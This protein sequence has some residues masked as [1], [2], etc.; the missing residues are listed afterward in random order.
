MYMKNIIKKFITITYLFFV[1]LGVANT[2]NAIGLSPV[3]IDV[4]NSPSSIPEDLRSSNKIDGKAL[5][6]QKITSITSVI[7][8]FSATIGM[9]VFVYAGIKM[10]TSRGDQGAFQKARKLIG[11]AFAGIV[12]ILFSYVVVNFL[13]TFI[14]Q[15]ALA[16][17]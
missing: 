17:Q 7:L 8:G 2:A 14:N 9:L 11:Y 13:I 12:I 10:L 16:T 6:G 1:V 4:L 3:G 5:V 15:R